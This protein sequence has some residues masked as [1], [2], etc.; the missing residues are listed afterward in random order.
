MVLTEGPNVLLYDT[1]NKLVDSITPFGSSATSVQA[2]VGFLTG[3][4]NSDLVVSDGPGGGQILVYNGLTG[5]VMTT[6]NPF[7]PTYTGGVNIALGNV[8][9]ANSANV[10]IVAAPGGAGKGVEVFNATGAFLTGFFPFT[11]AF[12]NKSYTGG[13][14]VAVGNLKGS[15][16]ETIVLGTNVPQVALAQLW[17]YTAGGFVKQTTFSYPGQGAY[18]STYAPIPGGP[19]DLVVGTDNLN[20]TTSL[21]HLYIQNPNTGNYIA[22]LPSNGVD[23]FD[24]GDVG[25]VR[26]S[27]TDVNGDGVPDFVITTGPGV[28]QEVRIFDITNANVLQLE[29]SLT[30]S[31]LALPAINSQ[32]YNGGLYIGS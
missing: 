29:Y 4:V 3:G 2:A 28:L 31:A 25:P 15:G 14:N 32:P 20:G 8:L 10:D 7:G 30:A 17:N 22:Q 12:P 24:F 5:P 6:I 1:A 11:A 26:V 21:S 13:L 23:L 9:T 27:V 16:P 19:A 18:V